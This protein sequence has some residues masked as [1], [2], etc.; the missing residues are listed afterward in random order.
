MLRAH[1]HP[2]TATHLQ[3]RCEVTRKW[4]AKQFPST[5]NLITVAVTNAV[6]N[7]T[8]PKQ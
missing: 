6:C 4:V 8:T 7:S 1:L 5:G 3:H 2:A